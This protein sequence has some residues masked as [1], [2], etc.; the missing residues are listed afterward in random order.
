MCWSGV[1]GTSGCQGSNPSASASHTASS[2]RLTCGGGLRR[3]AFGTAGGDGA[4]EGWRGE[5]LL[6]SFLAVLRSRLRSWLKSRLSCIAMSSSASTPRGRPQCEGG[7]RGCGERQGSGG[8]RHLGEA[9]FGTG[10]RGERCSSKTRSSGSG[11][12][13]SSRDRTALSRQCSQ[14]GER[15]GEVFTWVGLAAR[16]EHPCP[17]PSPTGTEHVPRGRGD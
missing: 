13:R 6:P 2:L 9:E 17:E 16:G 14:R 7:R 12:A 3:C 11:R 4:S 15:L 8:R 5:M 10:L 1:D